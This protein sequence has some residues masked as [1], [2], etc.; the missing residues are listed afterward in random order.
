M[1]VFGTALGFKDICSR[2]V[3]VAIGFEGTA[4]FCQALLGCSN[5]IDRIAH[6]LCEVFKQ[7]VSAV[8]MRNAVKKMICV[9]DFCIQ[10]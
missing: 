3:C 10:S 2:C 5:K 8:A 6:V 9:V 7:V 4:W 1:F